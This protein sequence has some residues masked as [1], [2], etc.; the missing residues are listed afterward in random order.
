VADLSTLVAHDRA[1]EPEPL[2]PRQRTRKRASRARD[3][4]HPG[5]DK[6]VHGLDV[7]RI[8]RQVHAEDRAVQVQREQFVTKR[9]GYFLTSGFLRSGGLPPRTAVA[10]FRAA[11]ADIS[12]RVRTVALAMCGARTTFGIASKPG[13]TAGSRSYTSSP[14]P[15]SFLAF[16][17]STSAASS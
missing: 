3:D 14:A 8:E 5:G 16:S 9:D 4:T 17:A 6:A 12:E 11:M 7:A 2:H 1:F 13:C 10:M 15:A